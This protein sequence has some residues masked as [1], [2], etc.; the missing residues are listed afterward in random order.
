MKRNEGKL[1]GYKER[2]I[3]MKQKQRGIQIINIMCLFVFG[4]GGGVGHLIPNLLHSRNKNN[5]K[6][7]I[8]PYIKQAIIVYFELSQ[9][10]KC[11]GL[12]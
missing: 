8:T 12:K 5:E 1:A 10:S 2:K 6:L 7:T 4:G 3:Q 9:L 11:I